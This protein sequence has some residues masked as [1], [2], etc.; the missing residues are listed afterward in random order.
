MPE[1]RGLLYVLLCVVAILAIIWFA[2]SV[3]H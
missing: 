2:I 1:G 3:M